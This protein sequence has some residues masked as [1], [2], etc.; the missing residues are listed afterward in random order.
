MSLLFYAS[1]K[2]LKSFDFK[3]FLTL[4]DKFKAESY[5]ENL[6][7]HV[8]YKRDALLNHAKSISDSYTSVEQRQEI[9]NLVFSAGKACCLVGLEEESSSFFAFSL[10]LEKEVIFSKNQNV[11]HELANLGTDYARVY[12]G[13]IE[14]PVGQ[15]LEL[16]FLTAIA[17]QKKQLG[18]HHIDVCYVMDKL[19]DFYASKH[20]PDAAEKLWLEVMNI[21]RNCTTSSG[22]EKKYYSYHPLSKIGNCFLKNDNNQKALNYYLEHYEYL[23]QE[24]TDHNSITQIYNSLSVSYARLG[25]KDEAD[26]FRGLYLETR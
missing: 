10:M 14:E 19:A 21:A 9:A 26:K 16:I 7:N 23:M 15:N 18:E 25:S 22:W 8:L 5:P 4:L 12:F 6:R 2:A 11:G 13:E 1:F 20:K 3:E 17:T 24:K